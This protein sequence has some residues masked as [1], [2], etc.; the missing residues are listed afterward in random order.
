MCNI[1]ANFFLDDPQF[2]DEVPLEYLSH[3]QH[4][5]QAVRKACIMFKKIKQWEEITNT[6][7]IEIYA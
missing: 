6:N 1:L 4:Y 3:Q 2:K 5:E 7:A